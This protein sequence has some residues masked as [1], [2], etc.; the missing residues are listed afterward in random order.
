MFSRLCLALL[1]VATLP[2]CEQQGFSGVS[3]EWDRRRAGPYYVV[4]AAP[5]RAVV[6]AKGRQVAIEP[7]DGFC[8]A[9]E[10]VE[11]T[12]RSAFALIG[13]CALD[14]S[15]AS[16]PRGSRGELQLPRGLPGIITV[17]ISGDPGFGER[18]DESLNDLSAF[19]DTSEGR[20]LLGRSGRGGTVTVVETRRIGD[21]VYV[22]VDDAAENAVPVLDSTFWRAFVELNQRLTVVT[23]SGFKD[24]PLGRDEMLKYLVEQI[25]TLQVANRFPINETGILVADRG[26]RDREARVQALSDLVPTLG[27][28]ET[29][30]A[31][32][33]TAEVE[34]EAL[35]AGPDLAPEPLPRPGGAEAT[36]A[37]APTSE[38][39]VTA[40]SPET[41]EQTELATLATAEETVP[42]P[43]AR[44]DGASDGAE[45][46]AAALTNP[47]S[48]TGDDVADAPAQA[49]PDLAPTRY[50]PASAPAAPRRPASV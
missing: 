39:T 38:E 46:T 31:A 28:V 36:E 4:S 6:S 2:S 29:G 12:G 26:R 5:D 25:Q 11:T 15:T 20:K 40:T 33:E 42:Q 9:R 43:A 13:D 1:V 35:A 18:S 14:T 49:D 47:A 24:R 34:E 8:L 27:V 41:G 7:A 37:V 50:A 48:N 22:L 10:S 30:T 44:P 17:S 19:L 21:G 16:A 32:Q 3:E 45:D 23:V